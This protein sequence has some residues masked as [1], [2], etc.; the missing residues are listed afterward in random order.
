MEDNKPVV[1][2]STEYESLIDSKNISYGV[3]TLDAFL[4]EDETLEQDDVK[5][6][7]H[8]VGMPE[9]KQDTNPPYKQIY[10]SFRNKEDYEE[11]AK[12]IDQH[13]TIKTKSIWHPKLDRDA[14]ALRRW[15]ETDD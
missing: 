8:W 1:D 7:K 14:N 11:F 13:L 5:W 15:I 9:F 12:L 6:K 3:S 2:E 4:P 10:V